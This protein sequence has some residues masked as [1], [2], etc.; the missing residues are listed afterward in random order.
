MKTIPKLKPRLA[1]L[2]LD[3]AKAPPKIAD[4]FYSS[5]AWLGLMVRLKRER[6]AKCERCESKGRVV[7][8]HIV[9]LADGG[10]PLDERN[11]QLLC[12]S[13]HTTKT[14]RA[15]AKRHADPIGG[16]KV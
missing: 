11:V 8:D 4:R 2:N 15:R 12:W 3:T 1:I 14:N 9:E 6:G 13:C 7:G 16:S 5:T 10:D